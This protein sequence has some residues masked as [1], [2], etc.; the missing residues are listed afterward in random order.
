MTQLLKPLKL[1]TN[2]KYG[3]FHNFIGWSG[4]YLEVNIPLWL[5]KNS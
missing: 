3:T 4:L 2:Y 5:L 1:L